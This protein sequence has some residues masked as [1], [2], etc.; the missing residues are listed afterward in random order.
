MDLFN[1]NYYKGHMDGWV[2]GHSPEYVTVATHIWKPEPDVRMMI[3]YSARRIR[4]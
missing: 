1:E 3:N 2:V 4:N